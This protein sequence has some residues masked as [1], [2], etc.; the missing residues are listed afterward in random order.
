M[1]VGQLYL[2]NTV[3]ESLAASTRIANERDRPNDLQRGRL[4][5]TIRRQ[6]PSGTSPGAN[7]EEVG[8]ALCLR[9]SREPYPKPD[10]SRPTICM[11]VSSCNPPASAEPPGWFWTFPAPGWQRKP[12]DATIREQR[13]CEN[14]DAELL[15][16]RMERR[17]TLSEA[18]HR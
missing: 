11:G 15:H 10:Y 16:G 9:S 8:Q 2:R 17:S 6:P 5:P 13:P 1:N 7:E 12:L 3:V 18:S 4:H 14:E